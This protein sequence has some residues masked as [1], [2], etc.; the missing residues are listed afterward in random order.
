MWLWWYQGEAG[1]VSI[2]GWE[3]VSHVITQEKVLCAEVTARAQA[4]GGGQP[5]GLES[6]QGGQ[7]AGWS[8]HRGGAKEMRLEGVTGQSTCWPYLDFRL[9]SEGNWW[10][11]GAENWRELTYFSRLVLTAA[12][13][14]GWRA[15]GLRQG[16]LVG[17]FCTSL[18]E[19]D[20][21]DRPKCWFSR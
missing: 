12:L 10:R 18:G 9:Y 14:M 3:E 11:F 17:G 2:Q 20:M 7:F 1:E 19:G 21:S 16:S 15:H 4:W 5:G 8:E 13:R 6:Q